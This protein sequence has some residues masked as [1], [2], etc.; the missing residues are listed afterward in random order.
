MMYHCERP[1]SATRWENGRGKLLNDVI[2]EIK[3]SPRRK[4]MQKKDFA[5]LMK[6][7]L[8]TFLPTSLLNT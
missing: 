7:F 1:F 8:L 2:K 3:G 4:S 6:L 5:I